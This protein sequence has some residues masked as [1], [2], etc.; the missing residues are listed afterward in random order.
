MT[1]NHNSWR[2]TTQDLLPAETPPAP[3]GRYDPYPAF[4][5]GKGK[6]GLGY[7]DLAEQIS[8][9]E[10]VMIDGF[11][12]VFWDALRTQLD[13][14]LNARNLRV[15][16]VDI[17]QAMLTPDEIDAQ[18]EPFLGGDD[19][20]F[21]TRFTGTLADFFARD[22]LPTMEPDVRADINIIYGCGAALSGWT[23]LLVYVDLP[24]NEL[25]FR[26][27]AG[28]VTNLGCADAGLPKPMYKRFYFVDW[29]ALNQHKA[30]LLPAIDLVVDGQRPDVPTVMRGDDLRAA[31]TTLS[32]NCFRVRPWFEPGP[33]G[34]QWIKKR[35][36][37][38]AQ[39]TPNY[40]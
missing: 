27:R 3:Y 22:K 28:S 36:P 32:E 31:L 40:A 16:W 2:T 15:N 19:P 1:S 35:I 29:V 37:Q 34:G 30:H 10:Q 38:L 12:G 11:V 33:W 9:Q 14:E 18:V 25:Q 26:A 5:V 24:K 20:I 17:R 6:I 21:G 7:G 8:G 23:G 13:A 4:P 39:D